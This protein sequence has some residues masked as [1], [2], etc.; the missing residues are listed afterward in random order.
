MLLLPIGQLLETNGLIFTP[1]SG[2]IDKEAS[3]RSN[4]NI[5]TC[6]NAQLSQKNQQDYGGLWYSQ[7]NERK[8][9][10]LERK[11]TFIKLLLSETFEFSIVSI[12]FKKQIAPFQLYFFFVFVFSIQLIVHINF[13]DDWIRTAYLWC[14]IHKLYLLANCTTAT[15][16]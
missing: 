2:H 10:F 1:T 14:S 8:R 11:T 13:A 15:A 12:A 9:R 4:I 6:A 3:R 7:N 16:H 5:I